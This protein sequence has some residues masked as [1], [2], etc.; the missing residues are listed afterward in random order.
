LRIA[1]SEPDRVVIVDATGSPP[2]VAARVLA[3]VCERQP[4]LAAA[5][6]CGRL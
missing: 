6:E 1:A 4:V 3:V 5:M 2:A